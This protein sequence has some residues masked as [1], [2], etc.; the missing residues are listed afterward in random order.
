MAKNTRT[1]NQN[2][3]K[4]Y[5]EAMA[6]RGI[7]PVQVFAPEAAHPLLK[8]AAG[9]MTREQEPVEPRAALRQVGGAN[10]PGPDGTTSPDLAAELQAAH[11]RIEAIERAAAERQAEIEAAAE[12]QRQALEARLDAAKASEVA[13]QEEARWLAAEGRTA[14]R[15][16]R[17]AQ[18]RVREVLERAEKAES[19]IRRAKSLPGLRG[20]L[21]RWMAGDTLD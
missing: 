14:A 5:R 16:T 19:T 11:A 15:L 18:E 3:N 21:M 10:E 17:E 8:Q 12:R 1:G 4:R 7:R 20:R 9:L 2:R 6:E 13:A